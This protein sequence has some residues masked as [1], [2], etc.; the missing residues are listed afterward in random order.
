MNHFQNGRLKAEQAIQNKAATVGIK[1][2][3]GTME[4]ELEKAPKSLK[5]GRSLGEQ[6]D[7][8]DALNGKSNPKGISSSAAEKTLRIRYK[9]D[10]AKI[11]K[12]KK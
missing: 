9:Y 5:A 10:D 11:M 8:I 7:L 12:V 6:L 1:L 2:E 4:E 3:N